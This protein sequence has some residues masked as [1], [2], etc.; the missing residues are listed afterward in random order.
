MASNP[1][2]QQITIP[3]VKK[4]IA[5]G[6]GKGGVGKSTVSTNLALSLRKYGTFAAHDGRCEPKT[7][8][9]GWK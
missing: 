2:D 4:I 7:A 5:V 6:S 3:G 9:R 8:A 1:F